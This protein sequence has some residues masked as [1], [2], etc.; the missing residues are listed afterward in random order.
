MGLV[1]MLT[2]TDGII[3]R[4]YYRLRDQHLT[5]LFK[6]ARTMLVLQNTNEVDIQV[7]LEYFNIYKDRSDCVLLRTNAFCKYGAITMYPSTYQEAIAGQILVIHPKGMKL[8]MTDTHVT[9]T[10]VRY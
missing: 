3:R 8:V 10:I 4:R 2:E 6:K 7:P 1:D 9:L 5:E